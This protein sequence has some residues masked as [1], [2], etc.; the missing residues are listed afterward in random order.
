MNSARDIPPKKKV[1]QKHFGNHT[2]MA[3]LKLA[4]KYELGIDTE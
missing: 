2:T 1:R 3:D 4:C